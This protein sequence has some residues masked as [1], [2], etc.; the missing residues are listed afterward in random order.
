MF[1]DP[2]IVWKPY[3]SILDGVENVDVTLLYAA[4]A[5]ALGLIAE[6]SSWRNGK[7]AE[8]YTVRFSEPLA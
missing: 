4:C 2:N 6:L 3:S 7:L 5:S 1:A 8:L